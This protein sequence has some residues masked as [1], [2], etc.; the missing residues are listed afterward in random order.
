[1]VAVAFYNRVVSIQAQG[2][3]N[4]ARILLH[5]PR[6]HRVFAIYQMVVGGC[7]SALRAGAYR[8]AVG[9][10]VPWPAAIIWHLG[11][12]A[13]RLSKNIESDDYDAVYAAKLDAE[14][15]RQLN[16]LE[17]FSPDLQAAV[18]LRSLFALWAGRTGEW[19]ATQYKIF[20]V[21]ENRARL[22]GA[23]NQNIRILEPHFHILI[24]I[25]STVHLDAYVKAGILGLRPPSR[26]VILH[27]PWLKRYAVNPCMLDYWRKY[28]DLVEDPAELQS[29]RP[30]RKSLGFNVAGPMQCGTKTIPWGHSAAVYVQERWDSQM[31]PPLLRLTDEHRMRGKEALKTIGLPEDAW[32]AALHVREGKFGAHRMAEPYRDADPSTYIEAITA[33]TSRGGWVVRLGDSSMS[34]L[35]KMSNLFDY[36]K[37]ELKSDWMDVFLCAAARF[38]IGCSSG[39]ATVSRAFGVP[40]ALVN[41]LPAGTLYLSRQDL[42]LPK[43]LRRRADGSLLLFE[44]QMSPPLST[45]TSDGMFANIYGIEIISN[46]AQEIQD[47]VEEM[48]DKLDGVP[49]NSTEDE[50]LQK[51]FKSMTAQCGTLPGLPGYELQGS[52]GSKFLRRHIDLLP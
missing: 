49:S 16:L 30:M 24:G 25:G 48:L 10:S 52:I 38:M 2:L 1:M 21:Q 40:I 4:Y 11:K 12:L 43:L 26:T 39:P 14:A 33:I 47:L 50:I 28:I 22:A 42:F 44:Q 41:Y 15:V 27:E 8:L 35:P 51:R 9:L 31:R 18:E 17:Q 6:F 36:A 13:E 34:P 32:F 29:L 37:S 3:G 45:C 19:L 23:G 20:E 7:R 5:A 46:T